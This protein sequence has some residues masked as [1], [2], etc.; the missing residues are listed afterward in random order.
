M[1]MLLMVAVIKASLAVTCYQC[2]CSG[3]A[4]NTTSCQDPFNPSDS[5]ET[6]EGDICHAEAMTIGQF[7]YTNYFYI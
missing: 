4:C 3:E 5:A 7:T 6:C 2:S 1:S